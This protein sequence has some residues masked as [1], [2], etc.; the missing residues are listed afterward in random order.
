MN[1]S[2]FNFLQILETYRLKKVSR[3]CSNNYTCEKT[4]EN[5]EK[6]ETV[7]EH[8]YSTMKLANFC[9][10]YF[11]EFY[12]LNKVKVYE[13]ILYHDDIEILTG[14]VNIADIE[15]RKKVEIEEVN[16]VPELA[17]KYPSQMGNKFKLL[18]TEYRNLFTREARFA[19][20]MDKLDACL[21]ELQYPQDWGY[22]KGF[23]KKQLISY[24][25][26]YFEFSDSLLELFDNI[27]IYIE[28]D[29]RYFTN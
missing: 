17:K 16:R 8:I 13:L 24:S 14:D 21:H 12:D 1:T 28:K 26:K 9:M 3:A 4:N 15:R 5:I 22:A 19:K 11:S 20:A 29:G 25:R 6:K 7:A 23:S 2:T 10:D 27:V 18:D